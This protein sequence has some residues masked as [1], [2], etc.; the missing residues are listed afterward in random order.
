MWEFLEL[1]REKTRGN[2]SVIKKN[3]DA[4]A[5]GDDAK[6][7][8]KSGNPQYVADLKEQNKTL[9]AENKELLELHKSIIALAQR[10]MLYAQEEDDE[11]LS[12]NDAQ[13]NMAEKQE[14]FELQEPVSVEVKE[15]EHYV[16]LAMKGALEISSKEAWIKDEGIFDKVY[17]SLLTAERYEDCQQLVKARQKSGKADDHETKEPVLKKLMFWNKSFGNRK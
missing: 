5:N 13:N 11:E 4:I 9:Y 14:V 15:P 10:H 8:D 12:I 6:M 17:N 1:I 2:I 7:V 3:N 16:D